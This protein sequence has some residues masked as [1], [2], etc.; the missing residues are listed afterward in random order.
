MSKTFYQTT[1]IEKH[2]IKNKTDKNRK[3]SGTTYCFGCKEYA[4]NFRSQEVKMTNKVLR[5]KSHC[6]V[7]QPNRS[8]FLKQKIN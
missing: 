5:A 6:V 7:F 4:K 2:K 8:R 3:Q 1:K